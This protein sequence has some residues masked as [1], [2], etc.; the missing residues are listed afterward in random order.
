MKQTHKKVVG[1]LGLGAVVAMTAVAAMIPAPNTGAVTTMTDSITVRVVENSPNSRITSPTDGAELVSPGAEIAFEYENAET[2]TITLEYTNVSGATQTFTLGEID[3]DFN[4]GEG[5]LPI[6]LGVYGYG[7]Y[8]LKVKSAG[9]DGVSYEDAISFAYYP[10][11]A[12]AEEN[13]ETGN[14]DIDLN[15]DPSNSDISEIKINV[16]D[17]NG[18]LVEEVSPITITPP[19]TSYSLDL[20]EY[21]LPAGTYTITVAAYDAEGNIVY[22]EY[23][24]QVVYSGTEELPVPDTG[25][26]TM[27]L[28]ISQTDYLITGL[29]IFGMVAVAGLMFMRR[30]EVK[31]RR[32]K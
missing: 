13:A 10:I 17:E 5:S 26:A 31:V 19:T 24:T 21:G 12:T 16:Y 25:H 2:V 29:I 28:G 15:Y 1:F 9:L 23:R 18:N 11:T 30:D 8:V 22:K 3:A 32:K 27:G 14:I 20:S 4:A 6:D 7:E